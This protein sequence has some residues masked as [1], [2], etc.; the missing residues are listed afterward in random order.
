MI[1][2]TAGLK[3]IRGGKVLKRG[4]GGP[5]YKRRSFWKQVGFGAAAL[6][7]F[8]LLTA[9][10]FIKDLPGPK[11]IKKS[12][13]T[14]NTTLY[15]RNGKEIIQLHGDENRRL[16]SFE[17]MPENVKHATIAVEDKDFYKHGGF[18]ITGI[19]RAAYYDARYGSLAQGGS[20]I[21]QQFVKKA[22]LTDKKSFWRKYKE[23][24]MSIEME[25]LYSK[26]QILQ[27]YLNEIPY[28]SQAYGIEAASQTF[29]KKPAKELDKGIEGL[30][31]SAFLAALPRAPSFYSPYYGDPKAALARRD[32]IL[33]L[34]AGQG[35]ITKDQA[36]QAK[37]ID[38]T[39][40]KYLNQE[41]LAT[42]NPAPHFSQLV[43]Q[44]LVDQFGEKRVDQG[45]LKVYT[46]LDLDKQKAAQQVLSDRRKNLNAFNA[47]NAALV[48]EDPRSGEILALVGSVDYGDTKIQG[49]VNVAIA[50]RQPGSSFKPFAYATAF[51]KNHFPG[52]TLFDLRTSFGDDGTGKPYRPQNYTTRE[53]GPVSMRQALDNSLNIS[54]V[55][56]LYL[57]GVS[58]TIKTA[59]DL[60]IT[61]LNDGSSRYG[62]SLVLGGGEVKLTDMVAAY[63]TFATQ[64]VKHPQ[65]TIKKVTEQ[66]GRTI[67]DN[68][69][70]SKQVLDK[71]IAYMISNVLSDN[72]A[73]GLVF[74]TNNLLHLGNRPVATKTGTTEN[75]RD[76]WTIGYTPSL[77][78]GVWAGNADGTLMT[79]GADSSA[80]AAP[81]WNAY[82]RKVL[83]G[84]KVEQ[85]DRPSG[86]KDVT[87]DALTGKKP[88]QATK[89]FR[90]DIAA[91][92][93]QIG[94]SP[95]TAGQVYKVDKVSGKL[96]TDQTP[97]AAI[98][99]RVS[100]NLQ[101]ELPS[102]D[103]QYNAWQGPVSAWAK[104][105]G[106]SGGSI[107]TEYD[108]AH[109]E[110]NRP[111]IQVSSPNDGD[112]NVNNP[113]NV[114]LTVNAPLGVDRVEVYFDGTTHAASGSGSSYSV[115]V[116]TSAGTHEVSAK[117]FDKGYWDATSETITFTAKAASTTLNQ[118][119]ASLSGSAINQRRRGRSSSLVGG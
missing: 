77:A 76:A 79:R 66:N 90:K 14:A 32:R 105:N 116:P 86:I 99:E 109:V 89:Q 27:M 108:D 72:A 75:F 5:F 41:P 92:W 12:F 49:N 54:A 62:L 31:Q 19:V 112:K 68:K 7:G 80:V 56:T 53:Y 30:S 94:T 24:V 48:A 13:A 69:P 22:V 71:Q 100:L 63:S 28:G 46:T 21:T 58:D 6:F 67:W 106:Y 44:Q 29:F 87:V 10:W 55:K 17:A 110:A 40:E 88:T 98:E 73:R 102:S 57:A 85:F 82:M 78:V 96:A 84:T 2:P 37:A 25:L 104:G 42:G 95:S 9:L 114:Q 115:S 34:M 23:L 16:I 83:D 65:I 118:Q 11:G 101:C 43:R 47:S 39:T 50:Q 20:T 64:G 15:D 8:F 103:P 26:D 91:S 117:V 52:S 36:K 33:D 4:A 51:K 45:G 61:T 119:S 113:V 3:N 35:Y 74:G 60:G 93:T 97:P 1:I 111:S 38:V 81:I 59:H 107:P 70:K 18:D